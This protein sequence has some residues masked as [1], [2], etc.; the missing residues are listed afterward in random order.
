VGLVCERDKCARACVCPP[1][2]ALV[3]EG[4][5]NRDVPSGVATPQGMEGGVH[6]RLL[7]CEQPYTTTNHTHATRAL[8]MT[9]YPAHTHSPTPRH[10]V[11]LPH[12]LRDHRP[13]QL[14]T[15]TLLHRPVHCSARMR[16]IQVTQYVTIN[17]KT[18]VTVDRRTVTVKGVLPNIAPS[19]PPPPPQSLMSSSFFFSTFPY[20]CCILSPRHAVMLTVGQP[21]QRGSSVRPRSRRPH[22]EEV[23]T[24][25]MVSLL[26]ETSRFISALAHF[27]TTHAT[28]RMRRAARHPGALVQAHAH[29]DGQARH[30]QDPRGLVV[31]VSQGPA[32]IL[33]YPLPPPPPSHT[34][35]HH[36]HH[37]HHFFM[38]DVRHV[39]NL[40][41]LFR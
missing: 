15:H 9:H 30:W 1:C 7:V 10:H 21:F 28:P 38:C 31:D 19:F 17:P 14:L 16:Q 33:S 20:C 18:E 13:I 27:N 26:C 37:H 3:C 35:A 29:G 12:L 2:A 36:H 8:D 4:T 5:T 11:N 6:L 23:E 40:C 25:R 22:R 24:Q 32:L 34:Q 41:V 39:H